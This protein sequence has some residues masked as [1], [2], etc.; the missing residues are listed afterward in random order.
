M[1][2]TSFPNSSTPCVEHDERLFTAT[3]CPSSRIPC[4]LFILGRHNPIT[5]HFLCFSFVSTKILNCNLVEVNFRKGNKNRII[6]RTIH[7]TTSAGP[8]FKSQI[9]WDRQGNL[10]TSIQLNLIFFN[11]YTVY[12]HDCSLYRLRE[13]QTYAKLVLKVGTM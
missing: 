13:V 2:D 3:S 9:C 11:F 1:H 4:S 12:F 7:T 5:I 6:V 10:Q 8:V